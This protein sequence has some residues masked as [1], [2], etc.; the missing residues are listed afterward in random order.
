MSSPP[1]YFRFEEKVIRTGLKKENWI[2]GKISKKINQE[3][4]LIITH[5]TIEVVDFIY[6]TVSQELGLGN[7]HREYI[8]KVG[9][10]QDLQIS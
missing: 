2:Q 4:L 9:F 8:S 3:F 1:I 10:S 5:H 7:L 6:L